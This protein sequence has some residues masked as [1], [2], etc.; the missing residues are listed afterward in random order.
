[1]FLFGLLRRN[2]VKLIKIKIAQIIRVFVATNFTLNL[3]SVTACWVKSD[4][5]VFHYVC[6]CRLGSV[7][8]LFSIFLKPFSSEILPSELTHIRRI[9]E[10][11]TITPFL[12]LM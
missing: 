4:S 2:N 8:P 10:I 1:M 7:L 11:R 3:I 12:S 6:V 5:M 9:P